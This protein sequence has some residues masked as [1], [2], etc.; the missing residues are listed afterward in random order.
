MLNM[1]CWTQ[2]APFVVAV[3]LLLLLPLLLYTLRLNKNVPTLASTHKI[4]FDIFGT[5]HHR[6]FK[7]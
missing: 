6:T 2:H 4:N 7:K 5:E 1:H 3:E